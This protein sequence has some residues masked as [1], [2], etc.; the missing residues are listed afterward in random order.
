M[1]DCMV[2]LFALLIFSPELSR[3]DR[4]TNKPDLNVLKL[5]Y[6]DWL[7][8]TF[9]DNFRLEKKNIV[10]VVLRNEL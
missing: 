1:V 7:Q 5:L 4:Q 10:C 2:L 6:N 3:Q 8:N 9:C